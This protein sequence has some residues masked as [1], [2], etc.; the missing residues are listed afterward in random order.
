MLSCVHNPPARGAGCVL[1]CR[2]TLT[3][4]FRGLLFKPYPRV[5]ISVPGGLVPQVTLRVDPRQ[6]LVEVLVQLK[7]GGLWWRD[8]GV[9]DRKCSSQANI[10]FRAANDLQVLLPTNRLFSRFL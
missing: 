4:C 6:P 9:P 3:F 10:C 8:F 1:A 7:R 5:I 2:N